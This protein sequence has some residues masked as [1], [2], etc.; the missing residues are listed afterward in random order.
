MKDKDP[1]VIRKA[2]H[3]IGRYGRGHAEVLQPLISLL[4]NNDISVRLDAL[5]ALDRVAARGSP[6]A[7][8]RID[9][10]GIEEEGRAIWKQF[11]AE[12]LPIQAR[13]RIR[14]TG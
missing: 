4:S 13:L 7:V 9:E 11:S 5:Y 8:R 12:A 14:E 2:S 6:E 3:M 10:L 1:L